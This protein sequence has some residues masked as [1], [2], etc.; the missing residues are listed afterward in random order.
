MGE[1]ESLINANVATGASLY[2]REKDN[3]MPA[4]TVLIVEDE[5]IVAMDIKQSLVSLGYN[6]LAIASTGQDAL[7][8]T[9]AQK[10][11]IVLMD[12]MLKGDIDGVETAERMRELYDIPIVYLTAYS[13]DATLDRAKHTEP[14]GYILKPFEERE[15]YTT[16][17]MALY[18]FQKEIKVREREQSLIAILR[19]LGDAVIAVDGDN[20]VTYVNP[21]AEVLSGR[22]QGESI[23]R[24]IDEFL[25]GGGQDFDVDLKEGIDEVRREGRSVNLGKRRL[26]ADGRKELDINSTTIRPLKDSARRPGGVIIIMD[27]QD[28][29]AATPFIE[30]KLYQ[31]R[32]LERVNF[33]Q[34]IQ[35]LV[36]NLMDSYDIDPKSISVRL[37]VADVRLSLETAY[38]CGLIVNELVSMALK[39]S[40]PD[41]RS[42]EIAVEFLTEGDR[43][44]LTVA[45][46][47]VP[48]STDWD[49]SNIETF[50]M[51]V[52]YALAAQ[53]G[54]SLERHV[55]NGTRYKIVFSV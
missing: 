9:A 35:N 16:I 1:S 31:Y 6:V 27:C 7:A 23:G 24:R 55:E 33:T 37:D 44:V 52:V 13:D 39:H 17:E 8:K 49:T 32:D 11:D 53:L 28:R 15:L 22:K 4:P 42:G 47:G 46:D 36:A 2:V 20:V 25:G 30:D 43:Y 51:K 19:C 48:Y 12:V 34:Y 3:A 29:S 21:V 41:D 38:S 10:P 26:I 54:G 40:F 14:F 5:N 45:D 18:K 50:E